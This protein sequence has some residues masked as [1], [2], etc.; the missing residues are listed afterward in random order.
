M[1]KQFQR[2][3]SAAPSSRCA[4]CAVLPSCKPCGCCSHPAALRTALLEQRDTQSIGAASAFSD[5]MLG[6]LKDFGIRWMYAGTTLR[7]LA[8]VFPC[9]LLGITG[10]QA[11][12]CSRPHLDLPHI[13]MSCL[14]W[15]LSQGLGLSFKSSRKLLNLSYKRVTND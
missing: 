13:P 9:P 10:T 2:G 14:G 7:H 5:V 1:H 3:I 11:G 4:C 6:M 8:P 12:C 15:T